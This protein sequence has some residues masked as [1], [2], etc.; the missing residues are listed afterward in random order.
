MSV[1]SFAFEVKKEIINRK[2]TKSQKLGLLSGILATTKIQKNLSY[3]IINNKEVF[4]Y[5]KTLL[6]ELKIKYESPRKNAFLINLN[7]FRHHNFK[8]ERDYF[9]GIFLASGSIN[10]SNSVQNHL[11]LKFYELSYA[12][13]AL[14]I[15]NKHDMNFK[16]HVRKGRYLIYIKRLE[17]IC[18]FLKAIDA[19]DAYYRFEDSI[20]E[21]DFFNNV[22]R[23]T[24]FDI[25]NQQRI[26]NANIVFLDN[27]DYIKN[28]HLDANFT[29]D[30]MIF[31]ELKKNNIDLSLNDLVFHL[32]KYK[33]IK[34]RSA[35]NHSLIK[36]KKVVNKFK[37]Q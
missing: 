1:S 16:L 25:Y 18:D 2:L 24:N 14:D 7:S 32:N 13:D 15:L 6:L 34:S 21:R 8:K 29:R 37:K 3:I 9:S 31:F 11:E 36:L 10:N 12:E 17:D 35:L 5:L 19:I 4:N 27:Y 22:N 20:I 33:I 30:E 26:A 28:N 23:I